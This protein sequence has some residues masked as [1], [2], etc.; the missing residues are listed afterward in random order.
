[1]PGAPQ[2]PAAQHTAAPPLL[3]FSA[4]QGRHWLALVA[5]GVLEA[6]PALQGT[7]AREPGAAH[8][9]SAQHTPEPGAAKLFGAQLVHALPPTEKVLLGQAVQLAAP[10]GLVKPSGH[11]RQLASVAFPLNELYLPCNVH[12]R[13]MRRF[14]RGGGGNGG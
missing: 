8:A 11:T 1:V 14:E 7:Q 13:A 12:A 4:A 9:P 3:L 5:P 10:A 6:V 2:N